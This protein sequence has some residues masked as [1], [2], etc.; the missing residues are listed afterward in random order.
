MSDIRIGYIGKVDGN[1]V[2]FDGICF[3]TE[4]NGKTLAIDY[5]VIHYS[6]KSK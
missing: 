3:T 5:D 6:R 2:F 4:I 1:K